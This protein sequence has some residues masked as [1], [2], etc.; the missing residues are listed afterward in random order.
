MK[1]DLTQFTLSNEN[2]KILGL[3][4]TFNKI[5]CKNLQNELIYN[6]RKIKLTFHSKSPVS[7]LCSCKGYTLHFE[8]SP[9]AIFQFIFY[10]VVTFERSFGS[11]NWEKDAHKSVLIKVLQKILKVFIMYV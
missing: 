7:R 3:E 6:I 4:E 2:D 9:L 5:S 11:V 10:L 8:D 1:K